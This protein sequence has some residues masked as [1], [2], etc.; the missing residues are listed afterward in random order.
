MRKGSRLNKSRISI[1]NTDPTFDIHFP[2]FL[3]ISLQ[4]PQFCRDQPEVGRGSRPLKRLTT[5][6]K[7]TFPSP[8]PCPLH[9]HTGGW[10]TSRTIIRAAQLHLL[11]GS[12]SRSIYQVVSLGS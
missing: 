4:L 7:V 5:G 3:Q 8:D 12:R 2:S 10:E 11:P 6:G 1:L 9:T